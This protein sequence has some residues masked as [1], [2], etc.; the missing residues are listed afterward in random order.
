MM[1]G[2]QPARFVHTEALALD[3]P[4]DRVFPLFGPLR[5]RIW[6]HDW[7]PR[8][9]HSESPEADSPGTVFTS[10]GP[11]GG[12]VAWCLAEWRPDQRRAHYVRVTPGLHL[13]DLTIVC[14]AAEADRT[15]AEVT[16][17]F[18][19]L[20]A[21]GNAALADLAAHHPGQVAGWAAAINHAL[22]TG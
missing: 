21:A 3:A 7:A 19:A 15:R 11:D 8:I 20:S 1:T 9:L 10:P 22:Q 4:P 16:Y 6:A 14:H 2:F 17:A 18:T 12:D 5:E 13:A